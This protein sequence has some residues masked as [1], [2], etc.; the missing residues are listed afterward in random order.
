MLGVAPGLL[1]APGLGFSLLQLPT[2]AALLLPVVG[3]VLFYRDQER[4]TAWMENWAPVV[5][6]L[7]D[8]RWLYRGIERVARV[9]G[10]IGWNGSLV[11]EGAGYLAWVTLVGL[12][13]L[14]LV[15][16]SR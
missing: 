3:A 2:W 9:W 4:I 5:E 13:V 12:V 8:V 7:L 16:A 6:R 10:T 1:G 15:L 11:I 14:L